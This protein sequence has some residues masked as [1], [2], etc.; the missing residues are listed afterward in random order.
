MI[1]TIAKNLV[2][3]KK[4]FAKTYWN[5]SYSRSLPKSESKLFPIN[6]EHLKLLHLFAEKNPIYYNSYE[7]KNWQEQY[8]LYM[9]EILTNFG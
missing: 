9:K 7:E 1:E 4:E 5:K 6:A 2:E 3:L 8:V